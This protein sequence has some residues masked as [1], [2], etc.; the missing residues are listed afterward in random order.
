MEIFQNKAWNIFKETTRDFPVVQTSSSN[1][2]GMGLIP[3][4]RAEIPHTLGLKHQN[5]KWKQYCN[6]FNKDFLNGP[7]KI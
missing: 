7:H 6:T 5:I 4:Q 3:D 1:P 2:G